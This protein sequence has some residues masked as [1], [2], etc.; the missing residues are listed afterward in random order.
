MKKYE[1]KKEYDDLLKKL[2]VKR[3]YLKNLEGYLAKRNIADVQQYL[4]QICNAKSFK[5]F[6]MSSFSFSRT[7]EGFDFWCDIS[8]GKKTK[9]EY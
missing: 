5:D 4:T 2:S 8:N 1:I 7:L 9:L 6:V 3:R